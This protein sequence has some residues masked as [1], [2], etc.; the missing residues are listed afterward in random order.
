MNSYEEF[1]ARVE[2]SVRWAER[3]AAILD[4]RWEYGRE[5]WVEPVVIEEAA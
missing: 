2:E 5:N 4:D 1:Q 3:R